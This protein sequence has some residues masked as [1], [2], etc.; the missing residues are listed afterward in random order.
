M[1]REICALSIS[2]PHTGFAELA[3][4]TAA[5][6]PAVLKNALRIRPLAIISEVSFVSLEKVVMAE[7]YKNQ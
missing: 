6:A 2:I 7:N 3:I 4:F 1:W 5:F